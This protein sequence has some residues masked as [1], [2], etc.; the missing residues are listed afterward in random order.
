[1]SSHRRVRGLEAAFVV[2][3]YLDRV[4]LMLVLMGCV[5]G[6]VNPW[7]LVV[8]GIPALAAAVTAVVKARPEPWFACMV[9][10]ISPL[11]F[12]LDVAASV[13]SAFHAVTGRPVT[14]M[15]RSADNA[16]ADTFLS[17]RLKL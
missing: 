11:M 15:G 8:Y 4:V 1:M 5:G 17:E 2:T 16:L 7:W 12:L 3:G 6:Y 14:W 10:A 9:I 13:M